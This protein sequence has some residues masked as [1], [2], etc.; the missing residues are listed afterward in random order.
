M[1]FR[2]FDLHDTF[3]K[4]LQERVP[5][6]T[7]L[8]DCI[9]DILRIEK[10][11]AYRR[12]TGRVNFSLREAGVIAKVLKIS[13]DELLQQD[14]ERMWMPFSFWYPLTVKSM[15]E[16]FDFIDEQMDLFA[17][18]VRDRE[19]PVSMGSVYNTLPIEF[20]LYSPVLTKFM[21]FRWGYYFLG[22]DEFTDYS[23]W[24]LSERA[25]NILPRL[26]TLFVLDSNFYIWDEV[27]IWMLAR[28]VANMN[29]MH[30][31]KD[32]EKQEIKFW[33][34]DML[35][36]LE[37]TLNTNYTPSTEGA[38]KT[39]FYVC[40]FHLGFTCHYLESAHRHRITFQTNF[41]FS[42]ID[43]CYDTT[44][45]Q[46]LKEWVDSFRNISTRLSHSGRTE[47]RL[48]FADQHDIL[49]QML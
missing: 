30:I 29:R 12:L 2:N 39:G 46:K 5:K 41:T 14:K 38:R 49:D 4:A 3:I 43:S 25:S 23:S 48:F 11:A 8:A 19:S 37:Q 9:S 6:K 17:N 10:E 22:T 13:I 15:D 24:Q 27:I 21:F 36:K 1:S 16:L 47:R 20:Y 18:V 7:D 44:F 28:E 31:I 26:K 32:E 33:L 40:P 42:V 34:K 35:D 45:S